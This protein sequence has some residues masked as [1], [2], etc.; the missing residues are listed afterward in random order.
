VPAALGMEF[1]LYFLSLCSFSN[2]PMS[3]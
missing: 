2:T 3:V 1:S